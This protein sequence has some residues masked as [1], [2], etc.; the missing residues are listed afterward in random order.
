[1]KTNVFFYF[2]AFITL[3]ALIASPQT[4]SHAQGGCFDPTGAPIA[5][6]PTETQTQENENNNNNNNR[7]TAT[8]IPP[9]LTFTNTPTLTP[10]NTLTPTQTPSATS[11]PTNTP[12]VTF[13]PIATITSTPTPIPHSNIILPGVGIGAVILLVIFSGLFP[14]IQKI[15]VT[16]R[17]Y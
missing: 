2:L 16:R 13:T 5:C 9:T 8:P 15:R 3:S 7:R 12:T 6:P 17:G 11:I 1:M 4:V 10:T 14:V